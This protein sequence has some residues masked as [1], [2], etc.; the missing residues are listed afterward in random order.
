MARPVVHESGE[1]PP[2]PSPLYC[3]Y[4]G[5][6]IGYALALPFSDGDENGADDA[7]GTDRRACLMACL[8]ELEID[9][10][11]PQSPAQRGGVTHAAS[12]CRRFS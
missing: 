10:A 4:H 7:G 8:R 6:L 9:I 11:V 12:F 3:R 2:S 5:F 1:T